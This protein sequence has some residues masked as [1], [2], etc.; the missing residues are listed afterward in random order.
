MLKD[1]ANQL[2]EAQS[3]NA[4]FEDK[5]MQTENHLVNAKASWASSEHER[6]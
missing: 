2:I 6:E 1:N 3:K 5:L 4:D